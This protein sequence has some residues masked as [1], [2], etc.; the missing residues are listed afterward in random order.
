[1]ASGNFG[2]IS[3]SDNDL[4]F[5]EDIQGYF[6]LSDDSEIPVVVYCFQ[7]LLPPI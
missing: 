1:M 4:L 2:L 5:F 7:Q 3:N 6:F